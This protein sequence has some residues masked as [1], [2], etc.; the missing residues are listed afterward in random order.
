MTGP[1]SPGAP[2]WISAAV[3]GVAM[4]ETWTS[5]TMTVPSVVKLAVPEGA[6]E[7]AADALTSFDDF[8]REWNLCSPDFDFDRPLAS[9]AERPCGAAFDPWS[10]CDPEPVWEL[11][12]G[13]EPLCEPEAL[14]EVELLCDDEPVWEPD[15]DD[16]VWAPAAPTSATDSRYPSVRFIVP[17][18]SRRTRA[19]RLAPGAHLHALHRERAA[20]YAFR[21]TRAKARASRSSR[22]HDWDRARWSES[23]LLLFRRRSPVSSLLGSARVGLHSAPDGELRRTVL[24]PLAGSLGRSAESRNRSD[25]WPVDR[26]GHH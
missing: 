11:S 6:A 8:R 21:R 10:V 2:M 12:C 26:T 24:I 9:G 4:S 13:A 15:P 14:G 19:P 23:D 5:Y 17:P 16:D 3:G 25:A 7:P 18:S 22:D 1:A 20:P